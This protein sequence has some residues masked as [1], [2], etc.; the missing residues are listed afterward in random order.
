M[1]VSSSSSVGVIEKGITVGTGTFWKVL[2]K[3]DKLV[4]PSGKTLRYSTWI[5]TIR[6]D[7]SINLWTPAASVPRDYKKGA[8]PLLLVAYKKLLDAG[9]VK[10]SP[11]TAKKYEKLVSEYHWYI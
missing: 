8:M 3:A 4:T 6:H 5:G 11:K 2:I 10:P 7:G 9:L 1:N